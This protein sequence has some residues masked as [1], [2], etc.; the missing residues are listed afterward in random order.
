MSARSWSE[1]AA[2]N[3]AEQA[4]R[5][6]RHLDSGDPRKVAESAQRTWEGEKYQ[7]ERGM[8]GRER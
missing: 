7:Q 4:E 2:R 8:E 6:I 1:E 5:Y 3:R